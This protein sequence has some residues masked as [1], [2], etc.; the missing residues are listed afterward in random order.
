MSAWTEADIS[1]QRVLACA[2]V[3][4]RAGVA[5]IHRF[6][7]PQTCQRS[8]TW[9]TITWSNQGNAV[10]ATC[11][12]RVTYALIYVQLP[13]HI[14]LRHTQSMNTWF[15]VTW[16]HPALTVCPCEPCLALAVVGARGVVASAKI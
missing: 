14:G 15:R 9:W 8:F 11:P 6:I 12:T 13:L 2:A 3:S 5:L 16:V 4:T 7:T 10:A 1:K